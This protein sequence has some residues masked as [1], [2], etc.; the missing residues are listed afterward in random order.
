MIVHCPHCGAEITIADNGGIFPE[1][2]RC[3][4]CLRMFRTRD[5][6]GSDYHPQADAARENPPHEP[7]FDEG[8]AASDADSPALDADDGDAPRTTRERISLR[9]T[10]EDVP[11]AL[12]RDLQRDA[13]SRQSPWTTAALTIGSL[14]LIALLGV[15]FIYHE[16]DRLARYPQLG[17]LVTK[18]C[19]SL[20]CTIRSQRTPEAFR[21]VERSVH[22]HP[23]F[24]DALIVSGTVVNDSLYPQPMPV[25]ELRFMDVNEQLLA[26]RRFTAEHYLPDHAPDVLVAPGERISLYMEILDPGP[27]AIAY[28]FAFL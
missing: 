8:A 18:L 16:R 11:H 5:L 7:A 19:K 20:G 4:T 21:L 24:G 14:L 3:R 1:R 17:P 22:S 6:M 12:R 26:A 27:R 15:Q 10:A 25:I 28:E 2:T 9:V 23:R 13:P